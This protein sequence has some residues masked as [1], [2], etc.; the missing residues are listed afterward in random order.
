MNWRRLR[1]I[2]ALGV[3]ALTVTPGVPIAADD[4]D[5]RQAGYDGAA[6]AFGELT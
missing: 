3:A 1:L 2:A 5:W 4:G 6:E